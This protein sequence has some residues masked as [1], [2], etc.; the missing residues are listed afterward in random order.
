MYTVHMLT[1]FHSCIL[2]TCTFWVNSITESHIGL[3]LA[4][5]IILSDKWSCTY[6]YCQQCTV[7]TSVVIAYL[8]WEWIRRLHMMRQVRWGE[9]RWGE[10]R[11]G[12]VRWVKMRWCWIRI[13]D[14][15]KR[16][17]VT[18]WTRRKATGMRWKVSKWS[19]MRW[20]KVRWNEII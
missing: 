7:N 12:E 5:K 11:W 15:M 2:P 4:D 19:E 14:Q 17:P 6:I 16:K 9:A 1:E 10:V 8:S 20:G 13:L 3:T 18:L